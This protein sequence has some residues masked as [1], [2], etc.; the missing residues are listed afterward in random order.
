MQAYADKK[1]HILVVDDDSDI[2]NFLK[3][4]IESEGYRFFAAGDADEA[5]AV[6]EARPIDLIILDVLLPHKN[7]FDICFE[8]R[9]KTK[10]P[11][12]FL[13]CRNEEPDIIMGLSAGADDYITKPFLPGEL[14]ARI[15]SNLRRSTTYADER[16]HIVT[17]RGIEANLMTRETTVGK[18]AVK[19]LPK[20]FDILTLFLQNPGR[21]FA[22][23]EIFQYIWKD[24]FFEGDIN[25]LT[26]HISNLRKKISIG[27][28]HPKIVAIKGIG[29]KLTD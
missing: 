15:R 11:V 5:F 24:R 18:T 13:S 7:G 17:W 23:E 8:L 10:A 6:L 22:K 25:T 26:V 4:Y 19:L 14:M 2:L 1:E 27:D 9:E 16:D 29:Y 20:E 21:V 3:V 12:I 28:T